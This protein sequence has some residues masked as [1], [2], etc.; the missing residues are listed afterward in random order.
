MEK[1]KRAVN[2]DNDLCGQSC[3]SLFLWKFPACTGG[4]QSAGDRRKGR[5]CH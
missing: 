4:S 3:G 2:Q 1:A 5:H